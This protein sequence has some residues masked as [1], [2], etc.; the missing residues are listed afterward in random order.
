MA[1]DTTKGRKPKERRAHGEGSIYQRKDETWAGVSRYTDPDTGEK[2]KHFVYGKTRKEVVAKKQAFED[3]IKKGIL[4]SKGK[5]TVAEWLDTWL[6]TYKKNS[7]RQNTFE[8]YYIIVNS[9]LKPAIGK[10]SLRELQPQHVQNMLNKKLASGKLKDG[11]ERK[12]GSALSPRMVEHIYA[13]LHMALGQAVKNGLVLRN[14]CNAVDK[15][16]KVKHEFTPWT[17]EESNQFLSSTQ[18]SR[19]FSLYVTAWGTGLRRSELLGLQWPDIDFKN[20]TLTVK[21][22]LV[23]VNGGYNFGSPKTKMSRRTIPLPKQVIQA[24]KDWRKVQA[25]EQLTWN[26]RYVDMEPED[27]PKYNPFNMVFC[28]EIGE[29]YKPDFITSSFQKDT[30]KAELPEIRFHDLRHGHATMLLELGE[31]LKVISDRL[32]HSTI[33]LTADTYSHVREKM[34]REASDKLE[35]VYNINQVKTP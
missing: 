8:S 35:K 33:T 12:K 4:P 19:L 7:V 15:P 5:I 1:T 30:K 34:Q 22:T 6:E 9:H 20:R 13:V 28:D 26:G 2:K 29:P 14:V 32:G 10:Y 25:Q 23:K 3:E 17:T 16:H 24:L 11:G 31:D 18:D 27:R 21:R